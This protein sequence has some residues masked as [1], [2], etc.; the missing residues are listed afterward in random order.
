MRRSWESPCFFIHSCWRLMGKRWSRFSLSIRVEV[1]GPMSATRVTP[2]Q[3]LPAAARAATG[4]AGC[5]RPPRPL[6]RQRPYPGRAMSTPRAPRARGLEHPRQHAAVHQHWSARP[7]PGRWRATYGGGGHA[8]ELAPAVVGDDDA[9]RAHLHGGLG[10]LH[11][12]NALEQQAAPATGRAAS[13]CPATSRWGR[14]ARPPR[15]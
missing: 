13:R 10:V 6:R 11:V 3:S 2:C 14:T 9:V 15:P 12:Q 7:R 5:A 4:P 8:V 1:L